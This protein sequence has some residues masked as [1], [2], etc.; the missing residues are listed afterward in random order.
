MK[1]T[2]LLKRILIISTVI[3]LLGAVVVFAGFASANFNFESL[4]DISYEQ[5]SATISVADIEILQMEMKVCDLELYFSDTA[6]KI[7][8]EYTKAV[9]KNGKA[10]TDIVVEENN[11]MCRLYQTQVY[12]FGIMPY[13]KQLKVVV[14]IPSSNKNVIKADVLTGVITLNG[15]VDCK[16]IALSTLNGEINTK[17]AQLTA[18]KV[19]CTMVNGS[20][21]V[22]I[23][24]ATEVVAEI[25]NGKINMY[26]NIV[27]SKFNASTV[28]GKI[29]TNNCYVDSNNVNLETVNGDIEVAVF[30]DSQLYSK[31]IGT[32]N[33]TANVVT[34]NKGER[35]LNVSTVNGDI[36][37]SFVS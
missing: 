14:T 3:M 33:G 36:T 16:E 30:G 6:D 10:I 34:E 15:N 37:I 21:N 17:N 32:V 13:I 24:N 12:M 31:T 9:D 19:S 35:Q 22:G 26:N 27:T 11:G 29:S 18:D 28:N 1:S 25:T 2:K 5:N 23:I 8:V 20:I 7:T 4:Y